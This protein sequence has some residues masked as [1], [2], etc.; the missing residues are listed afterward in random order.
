MKEEGGRMNKEARMVEGE[1]G[2]VVIPGEQSE[3]RN[4]G[5]RTSGFTAFCLDS[6]WSSS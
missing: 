2:A 5:R 6:R 4:P 1:V 3:T